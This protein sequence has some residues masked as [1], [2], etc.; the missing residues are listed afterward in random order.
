MKL[1]SIFV[2]AFICFLSQSTMYSQEP[3]L[4][5][6]TP[7]DSLKNRDYKVY[8]NHFNRTAPGYDKEPDSLF[9]HEVAMT[10]LWTANKLRDTLHMGKAYGFL[11]LLEGYRLD[12]LD[13]AITYTKNY[14]DNIQPALAYSLKFVNHYYSGNYKEANNM[15][16]KALQYARERE[17]LKLFYELEYNIILLKSDWGNK[18]KSILIFKKYL[19]F[20]GSSKYDSIFFNYSNNRKRNEYFSAQYLL[21]KLYYEVK[22]YKNAS[23]YLDSLHRYG[24]QNNIDGYKLNYYGLKGG[25]LYREGQY[26]EALQH[27]NQYLEENEPDDIYGTS[28]SLNMKGLILW[29]LNRKKE[30]VQSIKKAD[31]LYQITDDEFEEL[32]EGYQLLINYYKEIND[33]ESQLI[34]LNKLIGFDR[35]ISSNYIEI[36]NRIEQEYTMPQ[37][38]AAK[39]EVILKLHKEKSSEQRNKYLIIGV[40]GMSLLVVVYYM[41]K[42]YLNKKRFKVFHERYKEQ[43]IS[44]E[45]KKTIP[46]KEKISVDL[47][48]KQLALISKGLTQF[49]KSHG[50]LEN[51]ISLKSLSK[52]LETNSTYLSKYINGVKEANFTTYISDLRIHYAIQKLQGD[53]KFRSYTIEAIA[54]E[55]GFSNTRSFTNHFKRV[56]GI[57][58]SYFMKKLPLS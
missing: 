18:K 44:I 55:V 50:Y 57:T 15:L 5:G 20:M 1:T 41:R 33:T 37:L 6:Y 23:I 7:I 34:Y 35:K 13:K 40:L 51:A 16:L 12:Y 30:A 21:T 22:D 38:L 52:T 8:V 4:D 39:D 14:D 31:S 48:E 36:G 46:E 54:S 26:Q 24:F 42:N 27:T 3:I 43:K 10:Y 25:I 32:G 19:A 49:E 11:G 45:T 9:A 56:T 29:K 2:F 58:V 28:S 53:K 17:N 47:E